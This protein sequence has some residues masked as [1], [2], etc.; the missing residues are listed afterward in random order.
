MLKTFLAFFSGVFC[1]LALSQIVA[2]FGPVPSS[3]I[4][5]YGVWHC[6]SDLC[7]WDHIRDLGEFDSKNH[8]LIDRGDGIPAVNLV[9][10]SFVNP[11]KL[12]NHTT[13]SYTA[14][15][16]PLGMTSDIVN[17]FESK[18]IRV[19]LSIGGFTYTKDWDAALATD[20]SQLGI[21]A[22]QIAKGLNV[23]I[24]I[25]YENDRNPNIAGL[26]KFIDSYRSALPYDKTGK[27]APA[28]L[29][30]DLGSDDGYLSALSQAATKNW[31]TT[32][33]PVLDYANAMVAYDEADPSTTEAGWQEHVFGND[34]IRHWR[35]QNLQEAFLLRVG[36]M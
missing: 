33:R 23:G 6:G 4:Q 19:M 7:G 29:T 17:Y 10:L 25:D 21:D 8:W 36:E 14:N 34:S 26:E 35:Q 5:I 22:A 31:L 24:E 12:L 20:P 1:I 9:V 3:A 27:K 15:G 18:N 16:I 11:L 28:R 13:D 30:I 2:A 32:T